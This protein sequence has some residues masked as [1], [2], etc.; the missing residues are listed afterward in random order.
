MTLNDPMA[1]PRLVGEVMIQTQMLAFGDAFLSMSAV[2]VAMA[3]LVLFMRHPYK[4]SR[5]LEVSAH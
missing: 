2:I 4:T 3:F 1:G 5:P